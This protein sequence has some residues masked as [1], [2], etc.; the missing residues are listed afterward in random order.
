MPTL[1]EIRAKLIEKEQKSSGNFT[2]DNGIYAFWNIPEG[3]TATMRFL[4][5]K[6][7]DNTFFWQER[8]MIKIPFPGIKGTDEGRNVIVQVPCVEMWG[9]ECPVTE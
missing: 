2:Q 6:D 3:S 1:A 4:P 8:Q 5:D 9:T 7:E